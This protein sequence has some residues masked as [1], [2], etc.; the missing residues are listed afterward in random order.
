[1]KNINKLKL[2]KKRFINA[3]DE[4]LEAR[5]ICSKIKFKRVESEINLVLKDLKK[6]VEQLN[7]FINLHC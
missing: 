4:L 6:S 1:M 2:L 3:H 5:D 7:V